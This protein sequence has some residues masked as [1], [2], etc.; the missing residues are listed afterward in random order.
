L[1]EHFIMFSIRVST[2]PRR[3]PRN[4]QRDVGV[5]NVIIVIEVVHHGST[6]ARLLYKPIN[7]NREITS[8]SFSR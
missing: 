7:T 1:A 4:R 5:Y 8:I 2:V 6:V 3:N